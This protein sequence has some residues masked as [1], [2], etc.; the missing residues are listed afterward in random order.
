M[1]LKNTLSMNNQNIKGII[2]DCDGV[3]VDSIKYWNNISFEYLKSKT[4]S[5]IPEN[6]LEIISH[7]NL[8]QVA[9]YFAETFFKDKTA[10]QIKQELLELIG[11][12][13]RF[14]FKAKK[15]VIDGLKKF[16]DKGLKMCVASASN[17]N[18]I[19]ECFKRLNIYD[20]FEFIITTEEVEKGKNFPDIY[21]KATEQLG[22]KQSEVMI[23]EDSL[24]AITTAKNANFY[25]VAVADEDSLKDKDKIIN[26]ADEYLD[27]IDKFTI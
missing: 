11:Y 23:F 4:I 22:L 12:Q 15:G 21:I 13:Y 10:E 25:V 27:R 14:N 24:Y 20:Y 6:M 1:I 5:N 19:A 9:E 3:L 7:M 2:F 26:I 18:I 17:K 16:K 8:T